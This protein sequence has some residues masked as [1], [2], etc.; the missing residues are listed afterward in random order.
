MFGP[1]HA[2]PARRPPPRRPSRAVPA[3]INPYFFGEPL[4]T[5]RREPQNTDPHFFNGPQD[6]NPHF[7]SPPPPRRPTHPGAQG[8]PPGHPIPHDP[9]VDDDEVFALKAQLIE[10]HVR[11][12]GHPLN[13]QAQA[14]G[15]PPR[16]LVGEILAALENAEERGEAS[17]WLA[18]VE[19]LPG[20]VE[21]EQMAQGMVDGIYDPR[22]GGWGGRVQEPAGQRMG[23]QGGDPYDDYDGGFGGGGQ[24]QQQQQ[25]QQLSLAERQE[26]ARRQRR[27]G[28]LMAE[29]ALRERA[30]HGLGRF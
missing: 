1:P 29:E 27:H 20:W 26:R 9:S 3:D 12:R 7:F 2:A 13:M 4:P 6:I 22:A 23:D 24:Q 5:H 18:Y 17:P 25:E 8:F 11:Q 28:S 14:H 16:Q 30:M 21:L 10:Q 15:I 19:V